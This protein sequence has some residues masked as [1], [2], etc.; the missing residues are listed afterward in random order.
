MRENQLKMKNC[1][2]ELCF[3]G[4]VKE[5]KTLQSNIRKK[6]GE[7]LIHP[8]IHPIL[9]YIFSHEVSPSVSK[10]CRNFSR[11]FIIQENLLSASLGELCSILFVI[12]SS[13]F[14]T[15]YIRRFPLMP[16]WN[17]CKNHILVW[18]AMSWLLQTVEIFLIVQTI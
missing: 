5:R 7:S 2:T 16:K 1:E 3:R 17:H 9:C 15:L 14:A 11:A 12:L 4:F 6:P 8:E 13:I 10:S 18:R